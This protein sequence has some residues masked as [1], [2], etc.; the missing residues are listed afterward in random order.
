V[1]YDFAHTIVDD[2]SRLVYVELPSDERTPTVTGFV[3]R[4]LEWFE[5]HG[6]T[7]SG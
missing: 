6:I 3:A 1:G 2:H 5:G 4:V 7:P